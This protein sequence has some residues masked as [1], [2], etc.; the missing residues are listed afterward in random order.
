[1]QK[2]TLKNIGTVVVLTLCL[3]AAAGLVLWLFLQAVALGTGF[4]WRF[5]PAHTG[6]RWITVPLCTLGGFLTGLLHRQ[7][8]DYP[9]SLDVV[10]GKV[11][12]E[13]YYDYRP[14][15]VMLGCAL[16]PLIFGASVGPEA[17][18]TGIIAGLCYWVGDNVGFARQNATL[19][20]E[21]GEAVTLGQ[22]FHMPLFGILA[23]EEEPSEDGS[24]PAL[25]KLTKLVYYGLS[26][27]ASFLVIAGLNSLFHTSLE[28]FPSFSA[29]SS[30]VRDYLLVLL[31]IPVGLL[32]YGLFEAAEELAQIG[33]ER[34]PIVWREAAGGLVIGLMGLVAPI[35]LFSGEEQ[36]A[37]LMQTF[38]RYTPWLLIGIS[39]L[40]LVM[41]AFCLRFGMKGGH[42]FPLIFACVCMGFG[43]AMLVFRDPAE[44]VVFAAGVVTAAALG[45]Q[46]KK[47]LAV[48]V[49]M[50]LCFPPR[51]LF[52][53]FLAAAVSGRL[54]QFLNR[55]N[56]PARRAEEN[57][58]TT[59]PKHIK[60][61]RT[62]DEMKTK[63]ISGAVLAGGGSKRMGTA[64]A[65]MK[66]GDLTLLEIQV[67][68]LKKLGIEDIMI[69]GYESDMAG[70]RTVEDI[71]PGKG[72]LGG[73]H[74]CLKA[75]ENPVC[76]V[77]SVDTPL[78]PAEVLAELIE[79]HEGPATVLSCDGK[80]EP[81]IAVYDTALAERAEELIQ[82]DD[83]A[84]RRMANNPAVKK[85]AYTGDTELLLNCNTPED[86]EKAQ[87]LWK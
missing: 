61:E 5:L 28:G 43:L 57:K 71:Y 77:I 79:A 42:F 85:L 40:K 81:L 12:R 29:V 51:L 10:M 47:P 76:L 19:Y 3:G 63:T 17:G 62:Y 65:E 67:Q 20:S 9:E 48:S 45:A 16:L 60:Q 36:M 80:I 54:A 15:A 13:K 70:V 37:E 22:I 44:H 68:K 23:V 82:K 31:Y 25:P 86:F 78:V 4:V 75:A 27:A 2:T 69:S 38:G 84:V 35:V 14:M 32:M 30:S 24:L 33:A 34:F 53:I 49:L 56:P 52:W 64:K 21:L 55:N 6:G 26:M 8:G 50:L 59:T 58:T 41:T 83:W 18:L 72:P 87:S 11:K 7:F 74:A 46:L 39:V 1:M 66:L 73:V